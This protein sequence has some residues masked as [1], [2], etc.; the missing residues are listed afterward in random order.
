VEQLPTPTPMLVLVLVEDMMAAVRGSSVC[1]L[2]RQ[3]QVRA[4][5]PGPLVLGQ[6]AAVEVG[7]RAVKTDSVSFLVV[8]PALYVPSRVPVSQRSGLELDSLPLALA[9]RVRELV[10]HSRT[11]GFGEALSHQ[12]VRTVL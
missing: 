9:R 6:M 1:R 10:M 2:V 5:Q 11:S 7:S 4:A 3:A 12:E 8:R